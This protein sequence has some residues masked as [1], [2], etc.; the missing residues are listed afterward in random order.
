MR[1][2]NEAQMSARFCCI[3]QH[4]QPF[5]FVKIQYRCF[6]ARKAEIQP[7]YLR[8][9]KNKAVGIAYSGILV[10][11]WATGVGQ[12]QQLG[13]FVKGFAGCIINGFTKYFYGQGAFAQYYLCM[14]PLT[15]RHKKGKAG[16]G[17]SIRFASTWACI[18]CTPISGLL[19]ASASDLQTVR[20][21]VMSR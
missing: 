9:C 4:Q 2:C 14:P 17:A 5:A 3:N 12:A 1:C 19:S 21:P 8:L 13:A 18:W 11:Q 15:V 6:Q 20:L 10:N 7:R 16:M